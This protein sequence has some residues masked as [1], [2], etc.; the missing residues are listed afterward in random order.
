MLFRSADATFNSA[1]D[2]ELAVLKPF[3]GP[4]LNQIKPSQP[5]Y[6]E[7]RRLQE[8]LGC[9]L[10]ISDQLVPATSLLREFVGRS[11]FRY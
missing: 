1:L 10:G 3:A 4:L 6:A 8:F 5:E 2:Y 9:F 7:A 11:S